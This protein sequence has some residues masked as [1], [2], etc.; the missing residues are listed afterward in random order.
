MTKSW[1]SKKGIC[2]VLYVH[3]DALTLRPLENLFQ[4]SELLPDMYDNIRNDLL[5]LS[6]YEKPYEGI[7]WRD[8]GCTGK[9]RFYNEREWRYVPPYGKTHS[10][11]L[12]TVEYQDAKFNE[13]ANAELAA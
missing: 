5:Y 8:N 9:I 13:E 10:F 4:S 3:Q 6:A 1:G 11:V 12:E 7:A 2:P